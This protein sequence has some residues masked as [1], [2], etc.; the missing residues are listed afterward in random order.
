M[1]KEFRVP[2][3]QIATPQTITPAMEQAFKERGLDLHR[4]EVMSL[5]DDFVTNE[6]VLRVKTKKYFVMGT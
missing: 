5:E 2:H 1:P 3:E 4:H 6:R